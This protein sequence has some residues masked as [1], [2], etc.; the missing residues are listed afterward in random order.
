MKA[1]NV[2]RKERRIGQA[3]TEFAIV[4]PVL[5]L[6]LVGIVE[7][8][9][10]LFIYTN[11]FNAAR[12]GVRYGITQPK[13]IPGIRER[14]LSRISLVPEEDVVLRVWYDKGPGTEVFTD[15][16]YLVVGDRVV[17]DLQC[18]VGMVTPVFQPLLETM[19]LHT[20]AARTIQSLGDVD[21]APPGGGGDGQS[22]IALDVQADRTMVYDGETVQFT[23]IVTNTG[24]VDLSNVTLVDGFGNTFNLGTLAPGESAVRTYSVALSETTTNQA[25]VD[26]TTP[27]SDV[28]S[29]SDE[30]TV[31][32]IHPS[33]QLTASADPEYITEAGTTVEF[34]YAVENTGDITLTQVM[35][36]DDLGTSLGPVVLGPNDPPVVWTVSYAI[37]E[38]TVNQVVATGLDPLSTTWSDT[39]TVTVTLVEEMEPIRIDRPLEAGDTTVSG[40]AEPNQDVCIRDLMD[41]SF[42]NACVT[43]EADGSFLFDFTGQGYF[44][45]PGHVIEVAGYGYSDVAVVEGELPDIVIEEPLCHGSTVVSGTAQPGRSIVMVITD[46]TGYLYQDGTI[47]GSDG[48][49]QITL[50]TDQPLQA[51]QTVQVS[52]YGKSDTA[53]VVGCTT[54]AYIAIAPQCGGPGEVTIRVR[55]YNW[56]YQNKNDNVQVR[57]DAA[58]SVVLDAEGEPPEW[59]TTIT[60][61][62]TRGVHT[63]SAWN[64]RTPEVESTFLSPCPLPNLTVTSLELLTTEP[65]ST[66]LPLDFLVTIANVGDRPV[67]NLFWVD[68]YSADPVTRSIAWAAVGFMDVGVTL[69]LTITF[70]SGFEVTGTYPVWA[71][72]DSMDEVVEG[73]EG[74]NE[75]GPITV[76]VSAEGEP[77]PPPPS[78]TAEI[79][80]E[81][82][83]SLSGGL[84]PYPRAAVRLTGCGV[85][86]LTYSNDDAAYAFTALPACTYTV[87][88]ETWISGRRYSNTYQVEVADGE[89]VPLIII[90][91]EN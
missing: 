72:V 60:V 53:V 78:G 90:L 34:T 56:D 64:R 11:L 8:G 57:W 23:Y 84:S 24:E 54:D 40:T 5:L 1:Q 61:E 81:T 48:H 74:D 10:V 18:P 38:T 69:P 75:F 32:V 29:A 43:V 3:L 26:G 20:R 36:Q 22:G 9:R 7:F 13:D 16:A 47:V 73:D 66:Y 70:Q 59:E 51:D 2:R 86:K 55:G 82:W 68:L 91:Y 31:I 17:V 19:N 37:W 44:L 79:V 67:N 50:P 4:L 39:R 45:E 15:T 46:T 49:F 87:V 65:I 62:A 14:V 25:A 52:G 58:V 83:I 28:V 12:E 33:I 85:E 30:V 21:L 88:G 80:G 89:T 77:P 63:V 6:V 42:P 71:V 35:V 76:T 27:T 41:A